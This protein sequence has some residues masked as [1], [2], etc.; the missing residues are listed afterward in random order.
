[1]AWFQVRFL[2]FM[3]DKEAEQASLG[4]T[5]GEGQTVCLGKAS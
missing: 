4:D 2:L 5:A 1:V 3:K